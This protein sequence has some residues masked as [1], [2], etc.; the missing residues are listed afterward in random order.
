MADMPSPEGTRAAA[1]AQ[2]D[3]WLRHHAAVPLKADTLSRWSAKSFTHGWR[4]TVESSA[5][6]IR[7]DL[8]ID[9]R[10]PRSAPRVAWV[11]APPFPSLPHVEADGLLCTLSEA[12]E[13]NRHFPLGLLKFVL[14]N[15]SSVIEQGLSG[16][17]QDDF[18][19]EFQSYWNPLAERGDLVSLLDPSGPSRPI[20]VWRGRKLT[21]VAETQKQLRQWMA[22]CLGKKSVAAS[23]IEVG[24][25]VWLD[26][27]MLP[28]EYPN[29]ISEL[30]RVLDG[31]DA[32]AG[33]LLDGLISHEVHRS[34]ILIGADTGDG[35]CF[36][37]V[38][39]Q[40]SGGGLP[41]WTPLTKGF[42]AGRTPG[43]LVAARRSKDR[44]LRNA[45]ERAD[46]W[47]IHGRDANADLIDLQPAVVGVVGCGSLGSPVA[48]LL[49]Q[50]GVGTQRLFDGD[51]MKWPNT[52]RHA[53][54]AQAVQQNKAT[55]LSARLKRDFPHLEFE[56]TPSSW[57][58][59]SE[60]NATSL[61]A[62]DLIISTIGSWAHE[63]ELNDWIRGLNRKVPV[64]FGWS[65]PHACAGQA[66]V[67]GPGSGCLGCGLTDYGQPLFSVTNFPDETLLREPAC[68]AF[69]QPYG[70]TQINLVATLVADLALDFLCERAAIGVHRL[71]AGRASLVEAAGGELTE[72]WIELS[73][74]R[75]SGGNFEERS[76][77]PRKSC[78]VCGGTGC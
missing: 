19:T 40:Y 63:G 36:A 4:L 7:L 35:A 28:N 32:D 2:I 9:A 58:S 27:P 66:V 53:L 25:L 45:V 20:V 42:R 78:A 38:D 44:P 14:A 21:V 41:S 16:E 73:G 69:F 56:G 72:E 15:A 71:V 68:G 65:E 11:D 55:A 34:L 51:I 50:A 31:A 13:I 67:V 18:R 60:K 61:A 52:G 1:I 17:N 39:L 57:Q 70:A 12:D 8:L 43:W 24:I 37:G 75:R 29:T 30:R 5:G 54:G 74:H 33:K 62:C 77:G 6:S 3:E 26:R 59:A 46:A 10:F 47:W 76:W 49:A 23:R 48:R 64:L 22:N